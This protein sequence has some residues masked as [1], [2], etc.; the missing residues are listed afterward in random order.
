MTRLLIAVAG[1]ASIAYAAE[2][3][4]PDTRV[5]DAAQSHDLTQLRALI[6]QHVAV[7]TPQADGT[8]ALE[9]A[10]HWNDADAVDLLIAAGADARAG[11]RYGATPLSEAANLG[12]A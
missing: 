3:R 9:W 11:N 10:A 5:A 8:T 2:L 1:V 12:N 4:G 7:N 6:K